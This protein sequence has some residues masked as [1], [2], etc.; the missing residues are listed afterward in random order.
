M[1]HIEYGILVT[2]P[3]G[4]RYLDQTFMTK[5]AA[6]DVVNKRVEYYR[7]EETQEIVQR[8]VEVILGEWG[9]VDGAT[10]Q[11]FKSSI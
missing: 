5:G 2:T 10:D 11:I 4:H 1:K 3:E 7:N 6:Q 8:E 9:P